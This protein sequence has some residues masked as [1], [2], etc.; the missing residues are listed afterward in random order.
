MRSLFQAITDLHSAE[1]YDDLKFYCELRL[2]EHLL[3]DELNENEQA[4]LFK[5]IGDANFHTHCVFK[6]RK[7]HLV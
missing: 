4:L 6:C 7:V 2:E 1:L 5:M 3:D